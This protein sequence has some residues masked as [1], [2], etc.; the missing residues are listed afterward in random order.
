MPIRLLSDSTSSTSC[1][2][3][4]DGDVTQSANS[5][6]FFADVTRRTIVRLAECLEKASQYA[7]Q[8]FDPAS[9]NY[10]VYL[11]IM[12]PG[13]DAHAGLAGMDLVR[14]S[15]V[16]VTTVSNGLVASAATFLLLGGT[17]RAAMKHS[18]LLIHELSTSFW[19]K[20]SDLAEELSNST[21]VMGIIK[22]VY[23]DSTKIRGPELEQM[24]KKDTHLVA[25][26]C[27][28]HGFVHAVW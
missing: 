18:V 4:E 24:L 22:K 13:G 20:Y 26:E 21:I 3:D 28:K 2:A 27:L 15:R 19:G 23:L 6:H 12:S 17:Y 25:D 9:D 14:N 5:V 8:H 7:M 10:T 16:P 11:Y 1:C